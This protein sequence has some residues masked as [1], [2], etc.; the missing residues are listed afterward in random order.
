MM[1]SKHY[2]KCVCV[3]F[4]TYPCGDPALIILA[5]F[6][7]TLLNFPVLL[8]FTS[9]STGSGAGQGDFSLLL[10]MKGIFSDRNV[11]F[12]SSP[13]EDIC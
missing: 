2:A 8:A 9:S 10:F 4:I 11:I 6:S 3:Y 13:A 5:F 7:Y 1:V 12:L